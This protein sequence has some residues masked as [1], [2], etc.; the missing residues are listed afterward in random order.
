MQSTKVCID[1][2]HAVNSGKQVVRGMLFFII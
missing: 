2:K 1:M